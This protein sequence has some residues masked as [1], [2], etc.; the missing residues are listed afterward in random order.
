[1]SMHAINSSN[2]TNSSLG[3]NIYHPYVTAVGIHVAG[4]SS[5]G[6][7]PDPGLKP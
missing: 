2:I 5:Q 3:R 1:M 7:G 4:S 6:A